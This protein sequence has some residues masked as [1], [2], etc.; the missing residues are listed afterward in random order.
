MW[1]GPLFGRREIRV[2]LG[3]LLRVEKWVKA[4]L[5]PHCSHCT[6]ML[7]FWGNPRVDVNGAFGY[8]SSLTIAACCAGT[9][10]LNEY[11]QVS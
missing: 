4:S 9:S 1:R 10:F 11:G 6:G 5:G 8:S 3:Y 2:L 7:G